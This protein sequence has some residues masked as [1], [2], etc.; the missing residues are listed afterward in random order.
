MGI[1]TILLICV[2][3]TLDAFGVN[4]QDKKD[5]TV[6][7]SVVNN[8]EFN[9]NLEQIADDIHLLTADEIIRKTRNFY[10]NNHRKLDSFDL[11]VFS[12]TVVKYHLIDNPIQFFTD[13]DGS[14]YNV[15]GANE[16]ELFEYYNSKGADNNKKIIV[17]SQ[18]QTDLLEKTFTNFFYPDFFDEDVGI[19]N[20]TLPGPL[21]PEC[22]ENYTYKLISVDSSKGRKI[23]CIKVKDKHKYIPSFYGTIY[24]EDS[25]F[26]LR[27]VSLKTNLAVN[28]PLV[29]DISIKNRFE[30]QLD[31]N[32]GKL[33]SVPYFLEFNSTASFAGAVK[34]KINAYSET[35][36]IHLK[37]KQKG[38]KFDE[39][40]VVVKP[41]ANKKS[42]DFWEKNGLVHGDSLVSKELDKIYDDKFKAKS[43]VRF[44]GT[45]LKFGEN[46]TWNL[47][48]F[49]TFNRIEG[50]HIEL[51]TTYARN[52]KRFLLASRLI[53][54]TANE[55]FSYQ[56][57]LELLPTKKLDVLIKADVFSQLTPLF[58][59]LGWINYI[60][61]AI[62][63]LFTRKDRVNY[64]KGTGFKVGT[65]YR[66]SGSLTVGAEYSQEKQTSVSNNTN[67]SFVKKDEDYS[68][69]PQINDGY[70][71][72]VAF[73]LNVDFNKY[74]MID[75]GD[76]DVSRI[77]LSLLPI[78]EFRYSYSDSKIL[79]SSFDFKEIYI[80]AT[81]SIVLGSSF[82]V[83]YKG[84]ATLKYGKVP[85]Q[86]LSAVDPK[87]L[88]MPND[89]SMITPDYSEFLGDR[90]VFFNIE[91]EFGKIF[92]FDIPVL[93]SITLLG[94]ICFGKTWISD[95]N[96]NFSPD[97]GYKSTVGFFTE[98]GFGLTRILEVGTLRYSWRLNNFKEGS[99]SFL[100]FDVGIR[101]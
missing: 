58:K 33:Y 40:E 100:F 41:N 71:R 87:F 39:F 20:E 97:K 75:W 67:F 27:K 8:I 54:G 48:Y 57:K 12:R 18:R 88:G 19:I 15:L 24:I 86:E 82:K 21:G 17:E 23:Y 53:Y 59:K 30:T 29:K 2:L 50:N 26:A 98:I 74:R 44:T 99:N 38:V 31:S 65:D 92:P 42:R 11:H 16:S 76:G 45:G 96:R 72:K 80:K 7:I 52:F 6:K 89:V 93:S 28:I 73:T 32:T 37:R 84:G 101:Y 13:Y 9:E 14:D 66:V 83:I 85:Y 79:K 91:N 64:F 61:N 81:G 70:V 4:S 25:T 56:F 46:L 69:N 47:L 49:Y 43:F 90:I 35:K 10:L 94:D 62:S 3:V 63:T 51:N 22:F 68:I 78:L 34:L 1:R 55:E 95:E 5:S 36:S 60:E 77:R